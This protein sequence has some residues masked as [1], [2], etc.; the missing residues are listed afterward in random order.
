MADIEAGT[1]DYTTSPARPSLTER[2]AC[3]RRRYGPGSPAA[4][5]GDQRYFATPLPALDFYRLNTHRPLFADVRLRQAVNYA[6]DRAALARL[7]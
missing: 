6:I 3:A 2:L 7:G 1:A 4:A 5:H